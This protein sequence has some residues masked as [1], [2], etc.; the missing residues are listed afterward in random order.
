MRLFHGGMP[1]LQPGDRVLPPSRTGAAHGG[2]GAHQP[3]YSSARVYATR[4][5][6]YARMFAHFSDGDVY[7]VRMHDPRRDVDAR[8]S[9][10]SPWAVVVRVVERAPVPL[11][12]E[13]DRVRWLSEAMG[14]G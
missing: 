4:L 9:F 10:W 2:G 7:E 14:R 3:N 1:G 13:A 6:W 12:A 11:P 5:E 8:G